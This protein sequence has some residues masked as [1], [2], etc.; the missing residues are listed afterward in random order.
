MSGRDERALLDALLAVPG[1]A[2]A[3]L[4]P[5]GRAGG[6]GSLRLEL[7]PGADEAAVS[8]AVADL[9]AG[10][11]GLGVDPGPLADAPGR[12]A[13]V[14]SPVPAE[15]T[16]PLPTVA[17]P[18]GPRLALERVQLRSAGLDV[19]ASISLALDG[20][21]WSG[22]A[23]GAATPV[24]VQRA[25]ATATARAVE[26]AV[27]RRVRIEVEQVDVA[28]SPSGRTALVVVTL[29]TDRS[30][31]RLSGASVVREDVRQAVI[32]ATLASVNR[33]VEAYLPGAV[34]RGGVG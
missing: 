31:E 23:R 25:V 13:A 7:A 24:A 20:R 27:D 16:L 29:L 15:P 11:F 22:E 12:P 30:G 21:S 10:R 19:D 26:S 2:D 6:V 9:L 8:A 17:A 32:R 3:S 4:G 18:R 5:D 33:R 1:V 14:P 34:G 28:A